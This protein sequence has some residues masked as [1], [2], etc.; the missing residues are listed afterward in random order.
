MINAVSSITSGNAETIVNKVVEI[1]KLEHDQRLQEAA[2]SSD[3][4]CIELLQIEDSHWE[5][6][7]KVYHLLENWI[8]KNGEKIPTWEVSGSL[9]YGMSLS[10]MREVIL[11]KFREMASSGHLKRAGAIK[12]TRHEFFPQTTK[13]GWDMT[14]IWG[15]QHLEKKLAEDTTLKAAEHFLIVDE[16]AT[17]IEVGVL[18]GSRFPILW[19]VKNSQILSQKIV[20]EKKAFDYRNSTSLHDASYTDFSDP[21]NILQ[22]SK[23][24]GWVV[25]TEGK[26][27]TTPCQSRFEHVLEKYLRQRFKFLAGEDYADMLTFKIPLSRLSFSVPLCLFV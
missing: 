5:E 4:L 9:H 20:G 14:R 18:Q 1:E 13:G 11:E 7:R 26:S 23:G 8:Q 10:K 21:G 25:D 22:D 3:P 24:V 17:E 27:F 12:D 2:K 19:Q 15:A 6:Q 16:D